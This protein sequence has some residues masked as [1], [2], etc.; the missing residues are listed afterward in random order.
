[1]VDVLYVDNLGLEI[2]TSFERIL[3][4]LWPAALLA[5]FLASAPLQLVAPKLPE[6]VTKEKRAPRALA[7]RRNPL[8]AATFKLERGIPDVPSLGLIRLRGLVCCW[9]RKNRRRSAP[10]QPRHPVGPKRP[11]PTS[12]SSPSARAFR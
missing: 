1:M 2:G 12:L 11:I 5:F 10:Q 8:T 6:K 9:A 3:L 7:G 4:Q